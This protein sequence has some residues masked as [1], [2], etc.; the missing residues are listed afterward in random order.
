MTY[1]FF[2]TFFAAFF[3]GAFL[4]AFFTAF[5]TAF[6]AAF[7]VAKVVPLVFGFLL[8]EVLLLPAAF[9]KAALPP[10]RALDF[11]AADFNVCFAWRPSSQ[12][13]SRPSLPEPSWRLSSRLSLQPSSRGPS[14][15]AFFAAF[16][17]GP[18]SRRSSWRRAFFC[19]LLRGR[20]SA[21]PGSR[22]QAWIALPRACNQQPATAGSQ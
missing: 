20:A 3:A 13:S 12:P 11:F 14:W 15:R 17:A 1:F 22:Q 7:L 21:L 5:L 6:F 10:R 19:S 18:S 4:T 9:F 2:A 8:L 16:L